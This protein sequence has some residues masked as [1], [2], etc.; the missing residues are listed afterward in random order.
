MQITVISGILMTVI[1]I[2]QGTNEM[3]ND[4]QVVLLNHKKRNTPTKQLVFD[5]LNNHNAM[6][7]KELIAKTSPQVNETT[8]Y[9]VLRQFY[10]LKIIKET[11]IN[12]VR[13]IE[14]SEKFNAH[15]HHLICVR[16][17]DI[18]TINDM[19]LEQYLK[20]LA[21]RRGY[22][23]LDHSFEIQGICPAC[24]PSNAQAAQEYAAL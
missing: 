7:T 3:S 2:K 22:I 12:G 20:L 19:K 23:H 16:C 9:R 4:L 10:E 17:G 6:T 8:L 21:K 14:L 15:H 11:V 18:S 5:L 13:K 24:A 1:V